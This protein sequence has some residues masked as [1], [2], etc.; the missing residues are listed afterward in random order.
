MESPTL[1]CE[2]SW[3]LVTAF[4]TYSSKFSTGTRQESG[5]FGTE[6]KYAEVRLFFPLG[7]SINWAAELLP[8]AI[9][10]DSGSN[11]K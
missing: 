5:S 1:N 7:R 3:A 11:S 9:V 6:Y 10:G 2:L 8:L 4:L